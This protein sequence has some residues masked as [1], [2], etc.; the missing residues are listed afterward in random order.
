[1]CKTPRFTVNFTSFG[2]A[3]K[4][5]EEEKSYFFSFCSDKNERIGVLLPDSC[6]PTPQQSSI[7]PVTPTTNNPAPVAMTT[8][9]HPAVTLKTVSS[10]PPKAARPVAQ[11]VPER[12]PH[13]ISARPGRLSSPVP[14]IAGIDWTVN[15]TAV[16][17]Q[18]LLNAVTTAAAFKSP[19]NY[20][21]LNNVTAPT[22]LP[23]GTEVPNVATD[24]TAS[25]N[26]ITE[27]NIATVSSQ[28]E[29][30][31]GVITM[32]NTT[33]NVLTTIAAHNHTRKDSFTTVTSPSNLV[34]FNATTTTEVYETENTFTVDDNRI[35]QNRTNSSP[36]EAEFSTTA[37]TAPS[38]TA[39]T[40]SASMNGNP[41]NGTVTRS[42]NT[43]SNHTTTSYNDTTQHNITDS[44][45]AH[46]NLTGTFPPNSDTT[47]DK[48]STYDGHNTAVNS[49]A[50]DANSYTTV[51]KNYTTE[52]TDATRGTATGNATKVTFP[53]LPDSTNVD[54][55]TTVS[56]SPN[57]TVTLTAS[58]FG[59]S[60]SD[61]TAVTQYSAQPTVPRPN[62]VT[63]PATHSVTPSQHV[64]AT[65][66]TGPSVAGR[67]TA[68]VSQTTTKAPAVI[69]SATAGNVVVGHLA[70][71]TSNIHGPP[72]APTTTTLP[73]ASPTV[74]ST[75]KPGMYSLKLLHLL[76]MSINREDLNTVSRNT[77]KNHWSD[78][79]KHQSTGGTS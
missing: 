63:T 61:T 59:E 38:N 31:N 45:K 5:T 3:R 64:Y 12:T 76:T 11:T 16:A 74:F 49:V 55:R 69:P 41:D 35:H 29:Q 72:S 40:E 8:W 73:L 36:Y 17:P 13:N 42:I 25:P 46:N 71:D 62:T 65:T 34:Y 20:T 50:T 27:Y 53:P 7:Q 21:N 24:D 14:G 2:A 56:V 19:H 77:R 32:T 57:E 78:H 54:D 18:F 26:N 15:T 44:L 51:S 10:S 66:D 6:R 30:L 70:T 60:V 39:T 43:S 58:A 68:N 33:A 23:E 9:P 79:Q 47:D 67:S 28:Q 48:T 37:V 4:R 1:M 75:A 52:F 22:P